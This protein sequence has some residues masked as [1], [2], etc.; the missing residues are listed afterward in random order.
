[1]KRRDFLYAGSGLL[2]GSAV[3]PSRARADGVPLPKWACVHSGGEFETTVSVPG[4]QEK[5]SV[6]Q[7][8]DS[9]ISCDGPADEAFQQYSKRMGAAY[10]VRKH[11]KTGKPTPPLENFEE[12]LRKAKDGKFDLVVLTGDILNYPSETAV[13]AVLERLQTCGVPF[14]Y[15]AGNHDW[16]YEGM[17]G[18]SDQLRATWIEQRLKPLY[19][20]ADPY[21]SSNIVKGVNMVRIDNSTYQINERQLEFYRQQ[22]ARLE[23]VALWMHIPLYQMSMQIC[24]GHPDWGAKTDPHYKIE[25]RP[26]WPAE[27]CGETTKRFVREVWSTPRL[28]GVFTGHWHR[29]LTVAARDGVQQ[30]AWPAC[31]G[32]FRAL[33][34]QPPG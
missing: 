15:T 13:K 2:L 17:E 23:P 12:L 7:I 8:S 18:T 21:C 16:H 24:C 11:F 33:Q 28:A 29:A 6:L 30:L 31:D 10:A 1:M 4:L 14:L 25:R 19:E 27:G 34:F 22:K 5:L 9:H 26:Q 20:G 32:R 3:A